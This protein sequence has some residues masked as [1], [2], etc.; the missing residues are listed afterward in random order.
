MQ[1]PSRQPWGRL[2][3]LLAACGA[4]TVGIARQL[5]PD[6]ILLRAVIAGIAVGAIVSFVASV[7]GQLP[8]EE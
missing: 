4:I 3:G 6:V 5:D 8:S 2:C 7:I 1:Q